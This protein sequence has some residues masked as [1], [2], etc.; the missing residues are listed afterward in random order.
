M[1]TKRDLLVLLKED[2]MNPHYI[3][4]EVELLHE[5]L[6]NVERS[7]VVSQAHEVIDVNRYKVFVQQ[8][9]VLKAFKNKFLKPFIFISN[10]N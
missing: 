5:L 9:I 2:L 8:H 1:N 10:K 4:H 3:Q 7:G 6:Y